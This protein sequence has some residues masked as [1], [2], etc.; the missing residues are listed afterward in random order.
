MPAAAMGVWSKTTKMVG[1]VVVELA[2]CNELGFPFVPLIDCYVHCNCATMRIQN[3]KI[4]IVGI[5]LTVPPSIWSNRVKSSKLRKMHLTGSRAR[6]TDE[7]VSVGPV[8][9]SK[10]I[11]NWI[12]QTRTKRLSWWFGSSR[13]PDLFFATPLSPSR[14]DQFL[15]RA[16]DW[17]W[18]AIDLSLKKGFMIT[19]LI[20]RAIIRC[21]L[22]MHGL[23]SVFINNFNY[24][25]KG[26]IIGASLEDAG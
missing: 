19:M 8:H 16:T 9:P 11:P 14:K 20:P 21:S 6:V 7:F 25:G 5:E 1:V 22:Y 4:E 26:R 18:F 13:T 15:G 10:K 12:F 24:A 3:A 17:Q 2:V 23:W